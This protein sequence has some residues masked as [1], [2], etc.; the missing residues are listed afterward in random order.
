MDINTPL[1]R[2]LVRC[3]N[4][5]AWVALICV[6]LSALALGA[7]RPVSWSL[8]SLLVFLIAIFHFAID[9]KLELPNIARSAV[10]AGV[11]FFAALVWA[12]I[13]TRGGVP[14]DWAHPVWALAKLDGGSI[15]GDPLR[16]NHHIMRL[17]TYALVFWLS[18]RLCVDSF[19]A[20]KLLKVF[21]IF[22]TALAAFGLYA[23]M[24]GANVII[25][26]GARGD[27]VTASFINRNSYATYGVFG[28]LANLACYLRTVDPEDGVASG[29]SLRDF[30]ERFFSGSWVF[31][32]GAL[33]CFVAVALTQSRA[34]A[35][36]GVIGLLTFLS[37]SRRKGE[38]G[39][40]S[41]VLAIS[42]A[43]IFGFVVLTSISGLT[44][45]LLSTSEENGR[46][47]I[48]PLVI[49]GIWDRPLLG[50]GLG[51]F[52]ETFRAYVPFEAATG[53]WDMAHNSYLE[54]IYELGIPAASV[55]Y[56]GLGLIV[57]QIWRGAYTRRRDR[58]FSCF[59]IACV[60]A[61]SFHA[62][63][64]FSLQM[65]AIASAFAMILGMGWAQSFS[66]APKGKTKRSKHRTKKK[67]STPQGDTPAG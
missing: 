32:L 33:V 12:F 36:A 59:A 40:N 28:F 57:W 5:S 26:M 43:V 63:F 44:D 48:Y 47:A 18:F 1:I 67:N 24:S 16:G 21:A 22:S 10:P 60:M 30:L 19:Q 46:F 41:L 4:L 34:G 27:I 17:L 61:A 39:G 64:D 23:L 38:G 45:R 49:E 7:N 31:A 42:L 3:Q 51:A 14:A 65:P 2:I 8:L 52:Y 13:Q 55:F 20:E 9:M 54:N 15:S 66:T 25:G 58:T 6:L 56:L 29:S 35:L 37:I 11:L 62:I 53:E 50:H